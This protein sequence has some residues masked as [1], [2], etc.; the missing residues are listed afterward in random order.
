MVHWTEPV[1][2]LENI[3]PSKFVIEAALRTEIAKVLA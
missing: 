3:Y 1:C 2:R